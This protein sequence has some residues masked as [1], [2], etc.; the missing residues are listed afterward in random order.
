MRDF[1]SSQTDAA[2]PAGWL[3]RRAAEACLALA[4]S[5]ALAWMRPFGTD[6]QTFFA[7]LGYWV[8]LLVSW[9]IVTA[10]VECLLASRGFFRP[11]APMARRALVIGLAALPMIIIAGAATNAL[12]G[13][14]PS[15]SEVTEMYAQ[16]VLV[17]SVVTLLARVVLPRDTEAVPMSIEAPRQMPRLALP[18]VDPPVASCPLAARLPLDVR[19][20]I[21]CLEMEDHYVRVHTD[22]GSVLVLLRLSDAIAEANPVQGRQVHRSWWVSDDAVE[23]FERVG[24]VGAVRLSNGVRVPVSQRYLKSVEASFS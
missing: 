1:A 13:W 12:S 7:R 3:R 6:E 21:V 20:R 5:P 17:G 11:L 24:R 15:L 18:A 8:V 10:A 23:G 4:L 16:I 19:G 14:E 9:F 22:R 2:M